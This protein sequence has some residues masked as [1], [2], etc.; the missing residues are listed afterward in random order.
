MPTLFSLSR[1]RRSLAAPVLAWPAWQRLLVLLPALA[2]LWLGVW[3]A[4]PEAFT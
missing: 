3:W 1:L 2:L 4:L